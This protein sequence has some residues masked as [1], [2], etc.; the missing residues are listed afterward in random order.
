MDI[1]HMKTLS[2]ALM[3]LV[4][5][6]S[7]GVA[8]ATFPTLAQRLP[9]T[10]NAIIAV[11]LNRLVNSPYGKNAEWGQRM[12]D[13]W[14]KQPLMIP[15]GASLVLM[16]ADVKTN[17]MESNWE[18]SLMEMEK[19][20]SLESLAKGDG[21]HIDRVW[22]KDAV[23][24]PVN[25][26]FIP[27]D[28]KVLASITPAERSPIVRWLRQP[29]NP[30]GNVTSPYIKAAL[31]GLSDQTDIVMALDLDSAFGVPAIRKW[32]DESD[33]PEVNAKNIDELSRVLGAMNGITLEIRVTDKISGKATV[34]FD[35]D[36]AP[37]KDSAKP[38]MLGIL[39]HVGMR[40][41][42]I[43]NWTF[44]ASGKQ[45]TMQGDLSDASLSRL[46]S[47][48]Q[49]PVPGAVAV[50]PAAGTDGAT[51]DDPAL[52]SQKYYKSICAILDGVQGGKSASETAVWVRGA[53]KRVDQL[54]I[55]NVD[56]A[57]VEWGG[58]VSTKLKQAAVVMGVGQT[59]MNAR[60][61]GVA[62]PT[63]TSSMNY[64]GSTSDDVAANRAARENANKQRRQ[65]ALEQKAQSQEQALGIVNEIAE[66]RPKIRA[67]M[68]AKYKVEF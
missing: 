22:D 18:L 45:I 61:A 48:V 13:A 42:D 28:G 33:I 56:P 60:V 23:C 62:D 66:T 39:N 27:L 51:P 58:M 19:I 32:L 7:C 38:I 52:A 67:D 6:W 5:L 41:D 20:P 31:A 57:L 55:L 44:D 47:I 3:A 53:C 43:P 10:S 29:I 36:A 17:S 65:A 68:V 40:I 15:P 8:R 34:Q 30:D 59:Q 26:Y 50:V 12:A 1:R 16:A 64:N 25:A 37:L 11:N 63:Y 24:S 2:I 35:R 46:L 9:A 49:S 4:A 21:G 54:P 14:A